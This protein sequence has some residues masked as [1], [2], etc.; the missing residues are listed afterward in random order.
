MLP[1][2]RRIGAPAHAYTSEQLMSTVA[3]SPLL[4]D[5]GARLRRSSVSLKTRA[6]LAADGM[7]S[8]EAEALGGDAAV[9]GY[10]ERELGRAHSCVGGTAELMLPMSKESEAQPIGV[11]L[12]ADVGVGAVRMG[13]TFEKRGGRCAGV[14]LRY[15]PFRLDCAF[16]RAGQRR[17]HVTLVQE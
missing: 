9:R 10:D 11:A 5:L 2:W 4:S 6:T 7:P 14:G 17:V 15:G 12:F 8:Y 3:R 16:N 13:E 1:P